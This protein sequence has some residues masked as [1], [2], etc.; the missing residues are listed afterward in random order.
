MHRLEPGSAYN[1]PLPRRLRGALDVGALERALTEIVARHETLRTTFGENDGVP[2]QLVHPPRAEELEIVD[3]S[4][5]PDPESEME[6][7]VAEQALAPFDLAAGPPRRTVLL[8][9]APRTTSSR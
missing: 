9:L 4:V 1:V 8:R 6:R 7:L 2:F 3:I 5:E